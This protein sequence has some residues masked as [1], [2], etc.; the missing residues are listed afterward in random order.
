M[1]SFS[2]LERGRQIST[3]V[4]LKRSMVASSLVI[5]S[6]LDW[7]CN[8]E[9]YWINTLVKVYFGEFIRKLMCS[10]NKNF[11]ET[12]KLIVFTIKTN[13][14]THL[15]KLWTQSPD[16][17]LS[18]FTFSTSTLL[19]DEIFIGA[20]VCCLHSNYYMSEG[21]TSHACRSPLTTTP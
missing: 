9:I 6:Y 8:C 12:Q 10:R 13:S 19:F 14:K 7:Y 20:E 4:R 1:V 2:A 18:R 16:Q 11:K 17:V 15:L 3:P 21:N 5:K